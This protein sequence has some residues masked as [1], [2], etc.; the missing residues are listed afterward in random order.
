MDPIAETDTNVFCQ[1][2]S[3][4]NQGQQCVAWSFSNGTCSQW[5]SFPGKPQ[6]IAGASSGYD[7]AIRPDPHGG[8]LA[9]LATPL[10]ESLKPNCSAKEPCEMLSAG[11]QGPNCCNQD[12]IE[13]PVNLTSLSSRYAERA[14]EYISRPRDA[15]RSFFI[16]AA[17]AH[18]H[19]PQA[20]EPQW[21]HTSTRKTIFGDALREAD[22]AVGAIRLALDR[23]GK[24][25][26]TLFMLAADNGPWNVKCSLTGSQG[27]FAGAWQKDPEGGGGGATGKFTTWCE[28]S[29][30][31]VSIARFST[32]RLVVDSLSICLDLIANDLTVSLC[33]GRLKRGVGFCREGGHREP[34]IAYMPGRITAGVV[35]H[36]LASTMDFM[37]TF[38]AL[39]V[40][41]RIFV[42]TP[43][44][45]W[46][47]RHGLKQAMFPRV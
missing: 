45:Y 33:P 24:A 38:A 34:F 26:D 10:Y 5:D 20:Y 37:P 15:Q 19:V 23:T 3:D 29:A 18:M 2:T 32:I 8:L 4:S 12:I 11:R 1:G 41:T 9:A 6:S 40:G 28:Q 22:A 35:T 21:T 14:V 17:F 42:S 43:F 36:V 31:A 16:Y 39:A 25:A 44:F 30:R 13:Q 47:G 27:P 46:Q 7:G